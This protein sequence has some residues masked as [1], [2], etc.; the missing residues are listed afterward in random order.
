MNLVSG[1]QVFACIEKP[2]LSVTVLSDCSL[3]EFKTTEPMS[4]TTPFLRALKTGLYRSQI[5]CPLLEQ[6]NIVT[7]LAAAG[8]PSLPLTFG[9]QVFYL[10]FFHLFWT[11]D[12]FLQDLLL[13]HI[14]PCLNNPTA[15]KQAD[16]WLLCAGPRNR[17]D[18]L[19]TIVCLK[20][21]IKYLW[22]EQIYVS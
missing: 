21:H 4:S 6:P 22:K 13:S 10:H 3:A 20:I 9:V 15:H 18:F 11:E 14:S 16:C 8:M 12:W 5:P 17:H 19:V 2:G 7:G 1:P